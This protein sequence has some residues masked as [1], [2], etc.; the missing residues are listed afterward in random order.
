MNQS[1]VAWN[2]QV[3]LIISDVDETIADLYMPATPAMISELVA[4]L[5]EG[6]KI[7][8]VTG[9]GLKS[10]RW[11]IIDKIPSDL[12]KNILAAVCSGVEVCGFDEQGEV[13]AQPFY[14]LYK[15]TLNDQQEKDWREV[16]QQLISEFKLRPHPTMPVSKFKE[17]FG[18]DPLDVMLE[19]RDSQITFEVV[20]GFDL[21]PEQANRLAVKVPGSNGAYD[22]RL[23]IFERAEQL[24]TGKKIPIS[25]RVAGTF[26]IDFAVKG[27]SKTT[28][29]K[30][31]L[32][33]EKVLQTIGLKKGDISHPEQLEIWGDKFSLVNGGTDRHM[34]EAVSPK[35]R[36][37]DFR[38]E[39]PSELMPGYNIVVWNGIKHLH[40]GTLEYLH[41]RNKN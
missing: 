15:E 1:L 13:R 18:D 31:V 9:Q 28:S 26:A 24:L 34:S 14:S 2:P 10:V 5:K 30:H 37:I 19:D 41:T 4:L 12:R 21:T 23:P 32:D 8:F 7:F 3:K 17:Q 25:P 16:I 38:E 33:D 36:S 22:F 35:V 27:V 40:E 29:V 39:N 6:I 20:N 11:R